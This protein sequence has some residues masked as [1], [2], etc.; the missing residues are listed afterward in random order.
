MSVGLTTEGYE[1]QSTFPQVIN[2][3][4]VLIKDFSGDYTKLRWSHGSPDID[5]S[6]HDIGG[7]GFRLWRFQG[8]GSTAQRSEHKIFGMP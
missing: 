8:S 6:S 3:H 4:V 2:G 1:L 5:S 7:L